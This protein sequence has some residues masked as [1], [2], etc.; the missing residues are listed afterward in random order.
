MAVSHRLRH[1]PEHRANIF[2]KKEV[3]LLPP[4][5][6]VFTQKLPQ[7]RVHQLDHDDNVIRILEIALALQD[8]GVRNSSNDRILLV[9]LVK[10]RERSHFSFIENFE[11]HMLFCVQV[12]R[13]FYYGLPAITDF[14]YDFVPLFEGLG[15]GELRLHEVDLELPLFL[16]LIFFYITVGPC[17]LYC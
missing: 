6:H 1:L 5:T 13:F 15:G 8:P 4:R 2:F 11:S 17:R 3:L 16:P 10:L 12:N 7:I 9:S 14:I